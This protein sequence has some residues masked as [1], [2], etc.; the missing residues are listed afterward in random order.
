[1]TERQGN[2]SSPRQQPVKIIP[3]MQRPRDKNQNNHLD[4]TTRQSGQLPRRSLA[5]H[6]TLSPQSLNSN[7]RSLLSK[8]IANAPPVPEVHK[9]YPFVFAQA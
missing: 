6:P 4:Q 8:P 1:M 7:S 5:Q 3:R 9:K 2:V